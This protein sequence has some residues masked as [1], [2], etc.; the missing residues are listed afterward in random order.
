MSHRRDT[1]NYYFDDDLAPP[2]DCYANKNRR[3]TYVSENGSSRGRAWISR[4][5]KTR[6]TT[7]SAAADEQ[8]TAKRAR[9]AGACGMTLPPRRDNIVIIVFAGFSETGSRAERGTVGGRAARG[10]VAPPNS[11]PPPPDAGKWGGSRGRARTTRR[12]PAG[13]FGGSVPRRSR[14]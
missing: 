3:T 7:S 13:P 5:K 10:P 11:F 2:G 9:A 14:C 6:E 12:R 4:R 1:K 8:L